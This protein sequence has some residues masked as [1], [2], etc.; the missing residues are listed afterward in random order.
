MINDFTLE[1]VY[2]EMNAIDMNVGKINFNTK[3]GRK[4][5]NHIKFRKNIQIF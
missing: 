5:I 3:S 2:I 4:Q 1:G